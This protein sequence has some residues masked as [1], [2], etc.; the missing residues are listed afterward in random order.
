MQPS[1]QL[2]VEPRTVT[3]KRVRA[4]R[5]QGIV[6]GVIYGHGVGSISV[7][8]QERVLDRF[9]AQVRGASLVSVLVDGEEGARPAI[10]R[11]VQRHPITRRVQH[12]DLMQVALTEKIAVEVP[13]V[14][15]GEAPAASG[16]SVVVGGAEQVIPA[17]ILQHL[18][19]VEVE[20][21]PA[22]IPAAIEVDISGLRS[23]HDVIRVADIRVP[24]GVVITNPPEQVVASVSAEAAEV[25]EEAVAAPGEVQ[26]IAEERAKER[27]R[28]EEERR[29]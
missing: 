28:A 7:Q 15:V 3:G 21:L 14:L 24:A 22:D 2:T 19:V 13:V 6:P 29:E 27:R 17:V 20:A 8:V 10:V 1:L 25:E 26:V 11:A 9:L 23:L 18:S 4:L 12:F 5:R 16:V